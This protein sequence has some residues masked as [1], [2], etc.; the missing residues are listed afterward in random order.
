MEEGRAIR[1]GRSRRSRR[2][3]VGRADPIKL[4]GGP[5]RL[6]LIITGISPYIASHSLGTAV[7]GIWITVRSIA[8][9][10]QLQVGR[11]VVSPMDGPR[12]GRFIGTLSGPTP[13]SPMD[14]P[15]LGRFIG[16]LSGPTPV[17]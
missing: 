12:L 17:R 16:T 8:R 3:R 1:V 13:V 10:R 5:V 7:E 14:G 11:S 15:R 6:N 2:R 9:P 4:N